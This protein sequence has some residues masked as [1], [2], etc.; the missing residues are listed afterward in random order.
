[1][2]AAQDYF[3]ALGSTLDSVE[4]TEAPAIERAADLI[5]ESIATGG[6]V[7]YMGS[8]HS[9]LV[10]IEPLQ[11]A[12]GLASVNVLT[13]PA[14]S[15]T[16]PR[17]AGRVERVSGYAEAMLDL[18]DIRPGEVVVVVSN[19]GINPVPVEFADGVRAAGASVVAIT[20]RQ[21]SAAASSRHW[22]QDKLMDVAE[23]VIDTHAPVGDAIV[24]VGEQRAGAMSTVVGGA[25]V[26]ALTARVAQK[27]L[28]VHGQQPPLIVSQNVDGG[29]DH[30]KV[31]NQ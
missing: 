22:R 15:P 8:G 11:R 5:A 18:A 1:M 4:T 14:L 29:E 2:T 3:T 23:V 13:D 6:V 28:D 9:M 20:N 30:K 7:H 12:G 31:G 26:N 16:R 17:G 10:A 27:L 24:P 19:S 25:I 21:H